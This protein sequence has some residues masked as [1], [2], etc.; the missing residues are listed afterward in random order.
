MAIQQ[1]TIVSLAGTAADDALERVGRWSR[2]RRSRDMSCYSPK[3]WPVAAR[4]AASAY[5]ARIELHCMELPVIYFSQH[6]DPWLTGDAI[7]DHLPDTR[8]NIWH[9]AGH[10]WCYR[11]PDRGRIVR[12]NQARARDPQWAE[13]GW[14]ATR[15]LEASR[16]HI[17]RWK[18]ATLL[19]NRHAVSGSH[20]DEEAKQ[21]VT[22]MPQ[23]VRRPIGGVRH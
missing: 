12:R 7:S 21:A 22:K 18:S 16:A 4:R 14:L 6:V 19:I 20:S 11:L 2:A 23:W 8:R 1:W 10:L 5:L 13:T 3:D 15:L 17:G 9:D